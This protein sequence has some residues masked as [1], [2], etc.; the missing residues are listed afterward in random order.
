MRID[1]AASISAAPSSIAASMS[2]V[3]V[4]VKTRRLRRD[5]KATLRSSKPSTSSLRLCLKSPPPGS[6]HLASLSSSVVQRDADAQV[7]RL[8]C[9]LYRSRGDH[10]VDSA[11]A[12]QQT[13]AGDQHP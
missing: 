7:A 9:R 4:T 8:G 5:I 2:V 10:G 11:W 6:S 1:G 13:E 12:A 3:Y